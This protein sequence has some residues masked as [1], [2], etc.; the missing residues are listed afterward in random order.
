MVL[1]SGHDSGLV[2]GSSIL[3]LIAVSSVGLAD[4]RVVINE[5]MA[6]NDS[7]LADPQGRFDDWVEIYNPGDDPVN[8]AGMYLTDGVAIPKKWRIPGDRPDLT[9]IPAKGYLVLWL[10]NDATDVGLHAG[11]GLNA[12]GEEIALFDVD[13]VF[14]LD[15]VAFG[16]QLTDVSYGRFPD[17]D[18]VWGF[19]DSPTPA[20]PNARAYEGV[21]ADIEFSHQRGF[22]D[23]PFE[24][25][26]TCNTRD[27]Q[28]YCTLDGSEPGVQTGQSLTGY[29]YSTPIRVTGTTCLRVRATR[30]GWKPSEVR[31]HTYIFLDDVIRQPGNPAGFPTSWAGAS[32]DYEMDP[33]VV[34]DPAYRDEIIPALRSIRTMSIVMDPE[35]LFG[36]RRGIYSNATGRGDSWERPTSI[37]IINIDGSTAYVGQCGLRIH[38]YSWRTH[39]RTKKHSLRL[40]FRDEYGPRKMEYK[41]FPDAPVDRFD[42]IVL[43]AQ[44]GRSWAG[45]QYPEQAQYIRDAFARDTS[46]DM[47]KIDGHGAFVHLYLNGLYWGLYNPVER[48]DAQ[49]AEEYFGGSDEDYDALNRRTSTNEAVDGDLNRYNEMLALA[50]LG[51]ASP[52]AYAEMR[53]YVDIDNLIDFFLIHQYTTNKDGPEIFQSNN[54]RA[55]G[56]RIGDPKFKFFV[57]DMEYSIWNA[58][59]FLNINVDVPTSI[60][61]V[62]T[63]LRENPEFRL[64]YADRVHRHMFNGGALTP[65]AAAARWETRAR[66]IYNTIICESARWGDAQRARPYTRDVEWMAERNRL[67]TEY[68]PQR[69][70]ILLGQLKAAG[71]YPLIDAPVSYVN[72]SYQHGGHISASDML[73]MQAPN[74]KIYYTLDGSDPRQPIAAGEPDALTIL[75]ADGAAKRAF[76]PKGPIGDSWRANLRFNDL[77]WPSGTRGVGYERGSGYEA[78]IGIDVGSQM[79]GLNTTC[80][81][82]I[83]FSVEGDPIDYDYLTLK[84]RYD[85]GFVAYLNGVEIARS[86]FAGTPQWNSYADAG[87]EADGIEAFD[88]SAHVGLLR[89]DWNLLAIQGLNASS[90]SSDF[91]I[92]ADLAAGKQGQVGGA[93]SPTAILYEGPISLPQSADVKSRALA[94]NAWSALNEAV[95][96][97]GPVAENLRISEIMYHPADAGNPDDPNTEYVELTNTGTQTINLNLVEF[98]EGIEFI[99]PGIAL[100]PSGCLLVVKDVN[101]FEGKYGQGFNIAG[102]YI[103]R[104]D[105]AGE[106][107]VLRDAAGQSIHDLCFDDDWY[108]AT[109]GRGFSLVVRDLSKTAADALDDENAWRPSLTYDGSPGSYDGQ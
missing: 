24:V 78:L 48:P 66:E 95:F 39:D 60:S 74:G 67:L 94:S 90:T 3:L 25:T 99:F 87:H 7:I 51:L 4:G 97:V 54:Q 23:S 96:A 98:T 28:I 36:S 43:R 22:Y 37:E 49:F 16:E 107:I 108:A 1:Q 27:A 106:R 69:T 93:V 56:S 5:F 34:N 12:G 15:H 91:I 14:L 21:V 64:R 29:P 84:M 86:Q 77:A 85:D 100:A 33:D 2:L 65:D 47:G 68:F 19:L 101:A 13:G 17:G 53:R 70:G 109:D 71:L 52:Q 42:S 88:V 105:N 82:R 26:I 8:V 83:L 102:Q 30:P 6:A 41:L 81:I 63:K 18:E 89:R 79:Y 55:I 9:T 38:S 46:R 32:P 11:F 72:G 76:V 104:L 61:H 92:S 35:D 73:S 57:W 75:V 44:H 31:T 103:G 10:D 45:Q 62:Y 20:G 59:D 40:E 58:T 50:D 80:Y